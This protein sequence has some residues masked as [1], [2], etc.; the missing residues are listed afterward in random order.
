MTYVQAIQHGP[1]TNLIPTRITVHCTVSPCVAGG[2]M[3]TAHYF[4]VE[5]SRPA[6]AHWV[7]D[8]KFSVRCLTDN[9][10]GYHAPPNQHSLGY[11]M[12]DPQGKA[13]VARWRDANHLAMMARCARQVAADCKK[14]KIPVVKL[15]AADLRA[16]KHGIAGHADVSAAWH[17]T[18][19]TD[20]GLGFPWSVFIGMVKS[21][22]GGD[23]P[24][25]EEEM[26][27]EVRYSW[28]GTKTLGVGKKTT[29]PFGPGPTDLSL[30]QGPCFVTGYVAAYVAGLGDTA[31]DQIQLY[32]VKKDKTGAWVHDSDVDTDEER[33]SAGSSNLSRP[34][35]LQ[36]PAGMR[37]R[38]YSTITEFPEGATPPVLTNSFVRLL[39]WSA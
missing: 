36:V 21:Y 38:A 29:I 31:V 25:T 32:L 34:V 9:T 37:L 5:T 14:Y 20:P 3:V 24:Q 11:E 7:F 30:V 22:Y 10:V 33:G 1:K 35:T 17:E 15:S 18:T 8:P 27:T 28:K 16:G 13:K 4:H 26:P 23:V 6:S 19:H 12:T 39:K 2:A